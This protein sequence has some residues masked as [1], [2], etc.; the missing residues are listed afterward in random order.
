MWDPLSD[1]GLDPSE[2]G[3]DPSDLG[4]DPF[5]HAMS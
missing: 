3:L 5:S 4:S 1:V 2:V